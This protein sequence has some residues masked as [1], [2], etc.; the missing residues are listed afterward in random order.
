[1][2]R[3]AVLLGIGSTVCVVQGWTLAA[4]LFSLPFCVIWAYCGWLRTEPQLKWL[5]LMFA[6]LYIYGLARHIWWTN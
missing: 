6:A 1:M 2:K 5:N 3:F 4:M